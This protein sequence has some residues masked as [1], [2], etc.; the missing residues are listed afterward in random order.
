MALLIQNQASNLEA[1]KDEY[2]YQEDLLEREYTSLHEKIAVA[3]QAIKKRWN[4]LNLILKCLSA[5][6]LTN[7]LF[8]YV[9]YYRWT[10]PFRETLNA[11]IFLFRVGIKEVL[12]AL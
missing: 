5:L 12:N 7:Y 2:G 3:F 1:I 6:V 8:A 4:Y 10:P 9:L 11:I